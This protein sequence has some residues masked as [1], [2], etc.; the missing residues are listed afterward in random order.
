MIFNANEALINSYF[1]SNFNYWPLRWMFSS[2]KPLNRIENLQKK[3]L[4]DFYLMAM[5]LHMNNY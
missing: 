5:S 3:V 1:M 4:R 2:A